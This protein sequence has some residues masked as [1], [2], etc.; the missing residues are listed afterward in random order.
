MRLGEPP[1][2]TVSSETARKSTAPCVSLAR[3]LPGNQYASVNYFGLP[4]QTATSRRG[5]AGG[6][7]IRAALEGL[8]PAVILVALVALFWESSV[9]GRLFALPYGIDMIQRTEMVTA[10][11]GLVVALIVYLISATRTLQG[12]REHQKSGAR[13]EATITLAVLIGAAVVTL[14]PLVIALTSPQHPA[15]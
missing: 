15:P 13:M 1:S 8:L 12:V 6:R 3:S 4:S 7:A 10:G 9:I 5:A 11:G 2:E 14:I